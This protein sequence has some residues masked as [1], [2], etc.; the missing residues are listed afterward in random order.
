MAANSNT[1]VYAALAGNL[2]VAVTKGIAAALTGSS[3]M[4]SEAVHSLVDTGNEV[5]LLYGMHQSR[6]KADAAHPLGY[7]REIYF[8]SFIVALLI[9]A[10]GAGV[11][12]Y[13]GITHI[14]APE[15]IDRPWINYVVLGLSL[16]FEGGSWWV[17]LK[18]FRET[19]G[20]QSYVTAIT[21]SK[22]P[23][24]FMVLLEDTAALIGIVIAFIGTW[25]SVTFHEPRFD[26]VASILIGCV[27]AS[28]AVFLAR[29]SKGLLI[30]ERADPAT[31]DGIV[32]IA[33]AMP[34]V[35]RVNGLLTTQMSPSEIIGAM[36]LEFD[37]S[38]S[39]TELERL[40]SRMEAEVR[41]SYPQITSLFIK[42]QSPQ[43]YD[44]ARKRMAAQDQLGDPSL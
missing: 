38:L 44:A 22:D 20:D 13:E 33:E 2:L 40:V 19:K 43:I 12:V 29:E 5:L 9:F 32:R 41:A 7:G 14:Q 36:S 30:G 35:L 3:A 37:D 1:V 10:V 25:A 23:P 8:W 17:A 42:P 18:A 15:P 16:V 4:L 28:V 34:G 11:S 24:K 39:L 21:N 31:H 27:L 26:G 6:R